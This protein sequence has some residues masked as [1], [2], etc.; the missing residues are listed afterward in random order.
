MALARSGKNAEALDAFLRATETAA[1]EPRALFNLALQ[2]ERMH[3]DAD[4]LE[5]YRRY[6]AIGISPEQ[7]RRAFLAVQRLE[8][9]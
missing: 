6:I 1:V 4:A 5:A 7:R 3:K 8:R 9:K 2:L